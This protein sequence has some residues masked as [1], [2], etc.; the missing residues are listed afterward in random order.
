MK[1]SQHSEPPTS[2]EMSQC[3]MSELSCRLKRVPQRVFQGSI[4]KLKTELHKDKT[5]ELN[6][7]SMDTSNMF[8]IL[9]GIL[10]ALV[11]GAALS[12]RIRLLEAEVLICIQDFKGL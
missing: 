12:R 2:I 10:G 7:R 11:L 3:E 1:D 6:G 9:F 8:L 5:E 4:P